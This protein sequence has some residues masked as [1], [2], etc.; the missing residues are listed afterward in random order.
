M[1]ATDIS[2]AAGVIDSDGTIGIYKSA[3]MGHRSEV[4]RPRITLKQ[5]T[6]EAVDLLQ[7]LWPAHR[8]ITAPQASSR[9]PLHTWTTHS[10]LAGLA[11][12][13]LLPYLR[14]K[15]AQ[16][17]NLIAA[18]AVLAKSK[19]RH[20]KPPPVVEG[21]PLIT[22][23]EAAVL[24]GQDIDSAYRAVR[25]STVPFV[26]LPKKGRPKHAPSIMIPVSYIETW[27]TRGRP[28]REDS[29]SNELESLY[30][31]AKELNRVGVNR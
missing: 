17:E 29:V 20:P 30:L 7:E 27:R 25:R 13:D 26:R 3:S 12:T 8:T 31:R 21:E 16:A 10:R 23:A 15:R 1:N 14:I 18:C 6:P 11:A 24:I 4:Y 19:A 2:Y 5:V 9:R 28:G 22:L